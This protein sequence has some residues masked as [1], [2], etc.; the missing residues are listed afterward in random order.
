MAFAQRSK[1]ESSQ[2]TS[3]YL[4]EDVRPVLLCW[5]NVRS[6]IPS[7]SHPSC[8]FG[9]AET[10]EQGRVMRGIKTAG[11]YQREATL[12]RRG[13]LERRRAPLRRSSARVPLKGRRGPHGTTTASDR[14]PG[15]KRPAIETAKM[16]TRQKISMAER[17]GAENSS[18]IETVRATRHW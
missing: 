13:R 15:G 16:W 10:H 2:K 4:K 12:V 8:G 18:G 3:E 17:F 6:V 7:D 14:I 9:A 1:G 5:A 11:A